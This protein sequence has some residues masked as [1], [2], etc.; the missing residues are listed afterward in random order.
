MKASTLASN[1]GKGIVAGFAGTAAMT[2]S[3]TL[4]QHLRGRA[5]STAPADA[6]AK[7]LGISEF[8]TPAAKNRFS[9]LVHWGYGTGWG[10]VHALLATVGLRP[11]AATLAHGVAIWGNE[12]VM[13]PALDVAC[14]NGRHSLLLS[15]AGLHVHAIDRDDQKI[16]DLREL[17]IRL[18][19]T[20]VAEVFD[21]ESPSTRPFDPERYDLVLVVHYLHRPL[22]PALI[23]SVAPGG[24]LVYETFT[25]LQ[26]RRGKPT[27]PEF[28]LKP[29]E[30]DALVTGFRR[31]YGNTPYSNGLGGRAAAV[32]HDVIRDGL[33]AG[34][35]FH[36]EERERKVAE[37]IRAGFVDLPDRGMPQACEHLRFGFE[38]AL[39]CLRFQAVMHALDGNDPARLVLD[40]FVDGAHATFGDDANQRIVAQAGERRG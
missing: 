32:R 29:G 25:I 22:F 14:G 28:L 35:E 5:A 8:S 15:S 23:R 24:M 4:E 9:N 26:A 33:G 27:N 19:L 37:L 39:R 36:R 7:V 30:L 40:C 31:W 34:H 21:L 10:V 17:A 6:T 12:Q 16:A 2:V 11:A 20:L 38:S 18:H 13:L 3:S 1:I